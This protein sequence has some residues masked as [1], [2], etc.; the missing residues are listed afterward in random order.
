MRDIHKNLVTNTEGKRPLE[1]SPCSSR[2]EDNI[3]NEP[4]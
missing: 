1:R 4:T 3:K 2:L